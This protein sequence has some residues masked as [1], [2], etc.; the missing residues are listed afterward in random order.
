[1]RRP[2]KDV[3]PIGPFAQ[4]GGIR[5]LQINFR[6]NL[7]GNEIEEMEDIVVN[8]APDNWDVR[9]V[10]VGPDVREEVI[11]VTGSNQITFD[12]LEGWREGVVNDLL[13][14]DTITG[15]DNVTIIGEFS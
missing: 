8:N 14:L 3:R 15:L 5:Q 6:F 2:L 10:L 13:D 1:M 7:V 4:R 12:M 9:D 11:S